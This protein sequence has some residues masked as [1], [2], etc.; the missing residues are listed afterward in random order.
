MTFCVLS[1]RLGP[2]IQMI[3]AMMVCKFIIYPIIY[4]NI[5]IDIYMMIYKQSDIWTFFQVLFILFV[6]FVV[7]SYYVMFD[8]HSEFSTILNT[9]FTLFRAVLGDFDFGNFEDDGDHDIYLVNFGRI[10][11]IIYLIIGSLILLNLLIA[12]M[13]TTYETVSE[14]NVSSIVFARFQLAI[15]MDRDM[16]FIPVKCIYILYFIFYKR[17]KHQPLIISLH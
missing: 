7:G 10:I 5:L 3:F 15:E 16:S 14:H 6:G 4:N 17:K 9:S 2:M 12:L 8:I 11:M 1:K 13:A